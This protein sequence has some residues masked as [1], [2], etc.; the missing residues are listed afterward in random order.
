MHLT[1]EPKKTQKDMMPNEKFF[2]F[3]RK[4]KD[5]VSFTYQLVN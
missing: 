1:E 3:L 4:T 2:V 5:R